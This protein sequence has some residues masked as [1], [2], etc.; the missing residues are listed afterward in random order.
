MLPTAMPPLPH[1]GD[2]GM[3]GPGQSSPKISQLFASGK[4]P[5]RMLPNA[6]TKI[7]DSY[8]RARRM[9]AK[10]AVNEEVTQ[11][12]GETLHQM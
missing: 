4:S 8:V 5:P 11:A 2:A 1:L 6:G 7:L 10:A 3:F 12:A 9:W